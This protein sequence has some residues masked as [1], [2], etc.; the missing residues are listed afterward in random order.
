MY[1]VGTAAREPKALECRTQHETPHVG[2]EMFIIWP[3][4]IQVRHI[5]LHTHLLDDLHQVSI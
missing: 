3:L 1:R 2:G 4:G 5:L